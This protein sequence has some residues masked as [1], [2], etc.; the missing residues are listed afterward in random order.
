MSLERQTVWGKL[1]A[2]DMFFGGMGGGVFALSFLLGLTG[3]MKDLAMAGVLAGPL[4][5]ILATL[6]LIVEAGS[7][8]KAPRLLSGL[9]TSWMSRGGLLHALFV[10]FGLGYAIPGFFIADWYASPTAYIIGTI[11]AVLALATAAYHGMI[12]GQ[13][14]GI[15]LWSSSVLPATSFLTALYTGLG[16]I[17][18]IYPA[19]ASGFTGDAL[20][21]VSNMLGWAGMALAVGGLISLWFLVSQHPNATYTESVHHMRGP[22]TASFVCLFIALAAMVSVFLGAGENYFWFTAPMGGAAFLAA[23]LIFRFAVIRAGYYIPMRV[24]I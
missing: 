11:A 7:P 10:V 5:V 9:A 18:V 16:F 6:M 22:V 1:A 20:Q 13:A 15:P 4:L 21:D 23:G 12:M 3:N 17:L 2:L 14:Q 8:L 19:F 24:Y